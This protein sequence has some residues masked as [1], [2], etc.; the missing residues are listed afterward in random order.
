VCQ[1]RCDYGKHPRALESSADA[2]HHKKRIA[3]SGP[4]DLSQV[5][6]FQ[7]FRGFEARQ[8]RRLPG[9]QR[10]QWE[11]QNHPRLPQPR[12]KAGERMFAACLFRPHRPQ[13]QNPSRG[14][15]GQQSIEPLE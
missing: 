12:Q 10:L 14:G 8:F 5:R 11:F 9:I 7:R 13:H 2:L 15:R 6:A 4:E 3:T 1:A